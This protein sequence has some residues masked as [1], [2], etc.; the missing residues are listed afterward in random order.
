MEI[1]R[2][3]RLLFFTNKSSAT[4]TDQVVSAP[5]K[6][7]KKPRH[8]Q[9]MPL[10][11]G[12][13]PVYRG[14]HHRLNASDVRLV[15]DSQ[16]RPCASLQHPAFDPVVEKHFYTVT[17]GKQSLDAN[18][19]T[20]S[21]RHYPKPVPLHAWASTTLFRDGPKGDGQ[22]TRKDSNIPTESLGPNGC[23]KNGPARRVF[24][25]RPG[26]SDSRMPSDTSSSS[27]MKT[28]LTSSPHCGRNVMP[29]KMNAS[30]AEFVPTSQAAP[31]SQNLSSAPLSR[32]YK[33]A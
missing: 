22:M 26:R 16:G 13:G 9:S 21:F 31:H 11:T 14:K 25:T 20:T 7:R 10:H 23:L 17:F 1:F 3:L 12:S 2:R 4:L 28:P 27:I 24:V 6:L 5:R 18:Q 33:S 8:S 15:M 30:A 29:R 32:S 19:G